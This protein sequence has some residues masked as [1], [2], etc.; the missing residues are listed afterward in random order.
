M[1]VMMP[2]VQR[3]HL[4]FGTPVLPECPIIL[5]LPEGGG[6]P[7]SMALEVGS[8]I[9]IFRHGLMIHEFVVQV[10]EKVS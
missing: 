8:I 1:H 9:T 3:S 2:S 7:T 10:D 5:T 6:K 4:E